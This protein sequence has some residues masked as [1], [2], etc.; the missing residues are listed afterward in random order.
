[1]DDYIDPADLGFDERFAIG[2]PVPRSEDPVLLRGAGRYADDV[3]LPGQAYAVMV[4]S[5]HGHGVI[6]RI[7]VAASRAMPGVLAVYTAADLAAGGI[8]PLPPR[9]VMNNRDGTPMLSPTRFALATDKVRHVGEAVAAIIAETVAAAKDAAE[10]IVVDIDP[11]PAVT[12]PGRAA[13]PGAPLVHDDVPGNVGLDFHYGESAKVAAAFAAAAHVTRL[14]LRSNRIVVNPIEPRSAL[15]QYDA[16]RQHWTLHVESQGVFGFRNYIAGVLGVGRDKLRVLTDRVGGSFGMK[17]PT[18]AEYYCS[19]PAARE[20]GRPVKWTDDRSGS[21]LSDSHG[22]DAEMTAELAL[23]RDGN[24]LA[25]RLTGFGNLGATYG[26]PGPP[27]R[28]AVRNTLGVYKTPLIE[29]S[30]KCVF[31][32]TTPV[33]PYHGVCRPEADYYM[34]RLVDGT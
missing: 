16:E 26:A 24:F 10:A 19:L 17:Q 25:V 33:G 34:E 11:L 3:S 23:D 30:T 18:D 2:Q 8:G 29:V 5:P 9:Q 6:R 31:T 12:A 27:T 7:D 21:F 28:N 14:D 4:R 32:N 22:R 13:A 20:L 15:A 1:M